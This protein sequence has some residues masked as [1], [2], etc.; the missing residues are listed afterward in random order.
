MHKGFV[1]C[2]NAINYTDKFS[3]HLNFPNNFCELRAINR[4][5]TGLKKKNK[6]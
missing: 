5:D 1:S 3:A 6:I 4:I 2:E